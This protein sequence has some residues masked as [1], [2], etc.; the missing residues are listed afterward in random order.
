MSWLRGRFVHDMR[1]AALSHSMDDFFPGRCIEA[2]MQLTIEIPDSLV[3]EL[4]SDRER[5]GTI[6]ARGPRRRG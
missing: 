6:I 1:C 3:A 5:I 2:T 4:E